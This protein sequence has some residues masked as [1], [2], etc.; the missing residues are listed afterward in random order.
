VDE[1]LAFNELL[2]DKMKLDVKHTTNGNET[3]QKLEECLPDLLLVDI[4]LADMHAWELLRGVKEIPDL[5]D[6][7]VLVLMEQRTVI[8][9]NNAEPVF[10]PV[11][12]AK[13]RQTI[14]L[15]LKD[16]PPRSPALPPC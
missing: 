16:L 7:P 9:V 1:R 10:R 11:S 3:L 13:L 5:R 4:Q 8:P 2:T 12:M 14:W 15:S 6:M